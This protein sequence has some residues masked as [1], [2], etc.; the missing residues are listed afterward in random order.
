MKYLINTFFGNDLE[1]ITAACKNDHIAFLYGSDEIK[2]DRKFLSSILLENPFIVQHIS[3]DFNLDG[4]ILNQIC[5]LEPRVNI[6][7][8]NKR[9]NKH[10]VSK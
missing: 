9:S 10:K 3:D 4:E 8:Q 5:T 7:V 6:F 1:I 2:N